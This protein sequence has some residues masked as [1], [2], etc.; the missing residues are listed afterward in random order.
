MVSFTS[1]FSKYALNTENLNYSAQRVFGIRL[2]P[3]LRHRSQSFDH[4]LSPCKELLKTA[5]G[6]G[7][8]GSSALLSPVRGATPDLLLNDS[9]YYGSSVV[10]QATSPRYMS[11]SVGANETAWFSR[12]RSFHV[13][14]QGQAAGGAA[15][16]VGQQQRRM[17]FYHTMSMYSTNTQTDDNC[18]TTT[19]SHL[20][21][22]SFSRKSHFLIPFKVVSLSLVSSIWSLCSCTES[23]LSPQPVVRTSSFSSSNILRRS[24]GR[25]P[26]ALFSPITAPASSDRSDSRRS[27]STGQRGDRMFCSW[28]KS[29]PV[30]IRSKSSDTAAFLDGESPADDESAAVRKRHKRATSKK[31][32]SSPRRQTRLSSSSTDNLLAPEKHCT[33]T[34][35]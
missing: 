8:V 23:V 28:R 25:L 19:M 21:Q 15:A 30:R 11:T 32:T 31:S 20:D 14:Q 17:P 9:G 26:S 6:G 1:T 16:A 27:S 3:A 29:T 2:K 33:S 18:N 10:S 4:I 12:Q 13:H 5:A 22:N 24:F 34:A 7:G 35:R